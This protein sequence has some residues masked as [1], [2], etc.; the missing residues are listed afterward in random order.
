MTNKDMS[1]MSGDP[2]ETEGIYKNEWGREEMFKR[3]D[4]FP[5]DTQMGTTAWVLSA[6]PPDVQRRETVDP[7]FRLDNTSESNHQNKPRLHVDRGDK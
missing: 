6:F 7:R 3:G 1:P 2:V 4:I 5:A